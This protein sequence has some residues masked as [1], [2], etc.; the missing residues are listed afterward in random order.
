MSVWIVLLVWFAVSVL[1]SLAIG[2]WIGCAQK[3]WRQNET[4]A[5]DW[6]RWEDE[7][8]LSGDW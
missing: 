8:D 5:E 1:G 2:R 6:E 4:S 7:R 3:T